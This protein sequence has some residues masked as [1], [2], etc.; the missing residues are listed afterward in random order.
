MGALYMQ[1]APFWT[2]LGYL[3]LGL[4]DIRPCVQ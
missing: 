2:A 3:V 1:Y 4:P